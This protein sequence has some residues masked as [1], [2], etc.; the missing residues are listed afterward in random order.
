MLTLSLQTLP[1]VPNKTIK[2]TALIMLNK[3][4]SI[5]VQQFTYSAEYVICNINFKAQEAV[6]T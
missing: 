6:S 2:I 3:P 5:K 1:N 4:S